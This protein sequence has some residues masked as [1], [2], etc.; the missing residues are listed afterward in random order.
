G[1]PAREREV[2]QRDDGRDAGLEARV[3]HAPVV[4]E[5]GPRDLALRGIDGGPRDGE[6][7]GVEAGVRQEADVLGVA[8]VAVDGVAGALRAQRARDVLL[9]PPVAV[10]V[11]ALDLVRGG[12]GAP[13][14][15]GGR[16]QRGRRGG[17][18]GHGGGPGGGCGGYLS[19]VVEMPCPMGRWRARR[20][21]RIGSTMTVAP[22]T[23]RPYCTV[24]C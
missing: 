7:V 21:T 3:D 1:E 20:T 22:A 9:G 19:P 5:L 23:S 16:R 18:F 8:V 10:D 15:A 4:R 24:F 11:A 2:Q 6:P 14:E 12:R 13:Q 17:L